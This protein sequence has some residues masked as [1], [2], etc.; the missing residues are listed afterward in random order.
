MLVCLLACFI[1]IPNVALPP[2]PSLPEFLTPQPPLCPCFYPLS[3]NALYHPEML[4]RHQT[5]VILT[6]VPTCIWLIPDPPKH[7][8]ESEL[9]Y[10]RSYQGSAGCPSPT[11]CI[12]LT[13]LTMAPSSFSRSLAWVLVALHSLTHSL[14]HSLVHSFIHWMYPSHHTPAPLKHSPCLPNT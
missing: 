2:N 5:N 8:K 7:Q 6:R 9:A 12:C 11:F 1:Y 3:H 14:T 13:K 4:A 10:A